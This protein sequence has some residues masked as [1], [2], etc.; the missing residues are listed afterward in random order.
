MTNTK[1]PAFSNIML[2]GCVS[3]ISLNYF[4]TRFLGGTSA[5]VWISNLLVV[6]CL[7]QL[8]Y[9]LAALHASSFESRKDLWVP[10][11]L[12]ICGILPFLFKGGLGGN[13]FTWFLSNVTL[14]AFFVAGKSISR[15]VLWNLL[16]A[17]NVGSLLS[18]TF[19]PLAFSDDSRS[20]L[21]ASR[22][23]GILGHPNI[24]AFL[25]VC[26]IVF[27]HYLGKRITLY[28]VSALLVAMA[29]FSITSFFALLAGLTII[30]LLKTARQRIFAINSAL[31]A[32]AVPI[33]GVLVLGWNLNPEL[34]TSR[35]SIWSWLKAYGAPPPSGFG[36]AFL[37]QQQA[38][39]QVTWVHAHN[40]LFMSYYTQGIIGL[41]VIYLLLILLVRGTK[42]N[43]LSSALL[44]M[45]FIEGTTEI[46]LFLDY[47][48]G[49][50]VST[51]VALV[52]IKN[53]K[54]YN[55]DLEN[56]TRTVAKINAK[57]PK[58]DHPET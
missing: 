48:A 31:A 8:L 26:T 25:A 1:L 57:S 41:A 28:T 20:L 29:T 49:R 27:G 5:T 15:K 18:A 17:L 19:G 16:G 43:S 9:S 37:N 10:S 38:A 13:P 30:V 40:Q 54:N 42:F 39:G 32:M 23:T 45:L 34:F 14:A 4:V 22:L 3:L 44:V 7:G 50:W 52:L 47:P 35:S 56:M 11:L 53:Y 2:A 21:F 36:I 58:I 33:I 12:V 46:P 24:T 51:V 55:P 6:F